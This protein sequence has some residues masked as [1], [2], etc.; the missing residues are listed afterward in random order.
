MY[1]VP[2]EIYNAIVREPQTRTSPVT[3]APCFQATKFP[4]GMI[5]LGITRITAT[6]AQ[7]TFH[8]VN[9]QQNYYMDTT[10]LEACSLWI[11]RRH[12]VNR[13]LRTANQS[14]KMTAGQ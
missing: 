13:R 7:K 1:T 9:V 8:G 2:L 5:S 3:S 14:S 4:Q 6:L 11:G 12:M 10:V